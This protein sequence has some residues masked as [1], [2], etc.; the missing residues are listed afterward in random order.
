M[1]YLNLQK[2]MV[3]QL[4]TKELLEEAKAYAYDYIENLPHMDVS[5]SFEA[6]K[7]LQNFDEKLPEQ[8]SSPSNILKMLHN[9][10][11]KATVAKSGGK[12]FGFVNGGILP[13]TLAAKWLTDIWDQNSGLYVMSP[14]ASKLEEVC[15]KWLVELFGFQRGTAAGFVSGSSVA[16]ICAITAAR[17][18]LLRNQGHDVHLKGLF[19]APK[20]RVVVGEQAHS[21]I[22]KALSILGIGRE[23]VEVVPA[24]DQ[25][26]MIAA[27]LPL[28]DSKTLV[29]AQA[30][31]VTGG[32]FD[33][34]DEI[35]TLANNEGAW[36]HVD[37]AFGLWAA[38]SGKRSYLTKGIEKADSWSVD[39]HKTLNAPFDCGIVLCK[40]RDSL[41]SA[42]QANGS[43]L[44]YSNQRDGMLYVPELSKRARSVELWAAL[45][46]LGKSGIEELVD[47][48]CDNAEYFAE[49]L[50]E[51]GFSVENKVVFN[52]V[53]LKCDKPE[54][55]SATLKN[56][57]A[58]G[59][60]YSS[61]A[62]WHNEPAIRI[63][64]CSWQTTK[65]D[66]DD[67]VKTFVE[68]RDLATSVVV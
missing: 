31:N 61:G 47:G 34:L 48:L 41:V 26:R 49:K 1:D 50:S 10:G 54:I 59:K 56:I 62:K 36:V 38:V 63:S 32:A 8:S 27:K 5:P 9:Y 22:W 45:K 13:V 24:D 33:P 58:S 64:L 2:D 40:D 11:S 52:Q 42:M 18:T 43:Y 19:D 28:L 35:C 66:I 12:Y 55:T 57:Q 4:K 16:T 20:I 21:S 6:L 14:I 68:C 7:D 60:C 3:Q 17:N 67:C 37:G 25:G 39:A 23:M 29:I 53:V 65:K 51:N 44:Q 15:E 46:Y 30:G